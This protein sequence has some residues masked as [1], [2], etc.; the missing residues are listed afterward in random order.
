MSNIWGHIVFHPSIGVEKPSFVVCTLWIYYMVS[1]IIFLNFSS[2]SHFA[3]VLPWF[4]FLKHLLFYDLAFGSD[5]YI[6]YIHFY[7]DYFDISYHFSIQGWCIS[8]LEHLLHLYKFWTVYHLV[9]IHATYMSCTW[10]S[11]LKFLILSSSLCC[12]YN[13]LLF[14]H[15]ACLSVVII[16]TILYAMFVN[17]SWFH[18]WFWCCYSFFD[19]WY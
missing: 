6:H 16:S 14:F 7:S 1:T 9:S 2:F 13:W 15:F 10:C 4:S 11:L 12:C 19:L 18:M 17:I 8:A 5:I 3:I